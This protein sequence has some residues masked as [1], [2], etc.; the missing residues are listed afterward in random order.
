[1]IRELRIDVATAEW[2]NEHN[3]GETPLDVEPERLMLDAARKY[4]RAILTGTNAECRRRLIELC[5]LGE[6]VL[7][8]NAADAQAGE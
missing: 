3:P 2:W 5:S 6:Q 7:V 1:M 8:E 4:R